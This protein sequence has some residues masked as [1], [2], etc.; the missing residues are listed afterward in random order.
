LEVNLTI[1]DAVQIPN[2]INEI[3]RLLYV[4]VRSGAVVLTFGR[5]KRTSYQNRLMW[6]LLQEH[7]QIPDIYGA[8]HTKEDWKDILT[9][10]FE[11]AM[12][13]APNLDGTGFVALGVSTSNYSAKR[14]AEFIEFIYAAGAE[15]GVQFKETTQQ[16]FFNRGEAA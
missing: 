11:G 10:S 14:F 4:G 5:E 1:R 16:Q 13:Y 2:S 12:R 9:A 15:R 3:V 7:A 8:S 6:A